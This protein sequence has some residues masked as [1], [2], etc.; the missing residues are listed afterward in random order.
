MKLGIA[1]GNLGASQLSYFLIRNLNK[2]LSERPDF[3]PI[4]FYEEMAKPCLTPAFACMQMVEAW[5]YDGPVIATSLSTA[6]KLLQF[7][8]PKAKFFYVWDVEWVRFANKPFRPLADVYGASPLK[9]IARSESHAKLLARCWNKPVEGVVD[10]FDMT[11]LF[12]IVYRR[13]TVPA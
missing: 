6:S 5:G 9:L 13:D 12:N 1:L 4:V 10:D 11:Q 2:F 3:D 7:P 8:G